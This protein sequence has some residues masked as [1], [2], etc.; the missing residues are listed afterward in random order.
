M[1][2]PLL[3]LDGECV[4][5]SR[6]GR[7]LMKKTNGQLQ[8]LALQGKLAQDFFNQIE[9]QKPDN[10]SV[11]FWDGNRFYVESDAALMVVPF[12]GWKYAWLRLGWFLP[13][14][15]RNG[16]YRWIARNRNDWFGT[17]EFCELGG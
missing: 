5:C 14:F 7:W 8:I 6:L 10:D 9:P 17:Q 4:L 1:A 16:V 13:R 3:F 12:L 2:A 15:L 11:L